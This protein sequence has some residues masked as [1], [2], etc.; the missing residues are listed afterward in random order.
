ME[1]E[2]LNFI[3]EREAIIR[4]KGIKYTEI[5]SEI[6][7][8]TEKI[9]DKKLYEYSKDGLLDMESKDKVGDYDNL[10][11]MLDDLFIQGMKRNPIFLIL[12]CSYEELSDFKVI[13][14]LEEID[15]TKKE[16]PK[17]K[18]TVLVINDIF[19]ASLEE[20]TKEICYGNEAKGNLEEIV[21]NFAKANNLELHPDNVKKVIYYLRN[22]LEK[23]SKN[24]EA[25]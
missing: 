2:L 8:I 20:F 9:E 11:D 17:Y 10:V 13:Q 14:Y 12:K 24:K 1:K 22:E 16:N 25:K 18:L 19:P 6:I 3:N 21:Q 15:K 23:F 5:I 4:I 7:K